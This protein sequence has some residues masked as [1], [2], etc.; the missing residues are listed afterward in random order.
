M[1]ERHTTDSR[2]SAQLIPEDNIPQGMKTY[3]HWVIHLEKQPYN[4]TTGRRASTRD[5][6]TWGTFEEALNAYQTGRWSG[7]GF[8]F[9]SGDPYTGIDLDKCRDPETGGI[10]PWAQELIGRFD[11]Y[12]EVSPTGTGIHIITTGQ[13]P[14]NGKRTVDGKTVE[15][16]S[17]ARYFTITGV[18]P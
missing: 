5:S 12:T 11:S 16:Y 10:E 18:R 8:V 7:I 15:I 4:P 1:V 9:S 17:V 13:T 3:R 2:S 6:R 14:H